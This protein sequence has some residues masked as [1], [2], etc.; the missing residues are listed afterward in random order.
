MA[1]RTLSLVDR[2]VLLG[3]PGLGDLALRRHA[4]GQPSDTA[5]DHRTR[6]LVMRPRMNGTG[7]DHD[8]VFDD[9]V[10]QRPLIRR[11]RL[12]GGKARAPKVTA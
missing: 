8:I 9:R 12:V 6:P 3:S 10:A 7:I 11:T 5:A 2:N 1:G 4:L